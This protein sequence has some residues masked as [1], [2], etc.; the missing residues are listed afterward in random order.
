[1]PKNKQSFLKITLIN[2]L[3][4]GIMAL[5]LTVTGEITIRSFIPSPDHSGMVRLTSTPITYE[6]I[7][8]LDIVRE[9]VRIKTNSDGFR[10]SK[11]QVNQNRDSL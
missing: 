6:M 10:D 1:M 11:L 8:N 9:G 4:L 3:I 5:L 2:L 7:P